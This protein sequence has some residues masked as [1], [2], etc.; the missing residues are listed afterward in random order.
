[1]TNLGGH[2]AIGADARAAAGL[3]F[4]D[5][6]GQAH[7]DEA[8]VAHLIDKKV[9]GLE[10]AVENVLHVAV[11][12]H[13]DDL[14]DDEAHLLGGETLLSEDKLGE[15]TSRYQIHHQDE[16]LR[17][18][19]R[20]REIDKEWVVEAGHQILL[21]MNLLAPR[22]SKAPTHHLLMHNLHRVMLA[23]VTLHHLEHLAEA[24][25][26]EDTYQPEVG[27]AGYKA[28]LG[29]EL[30]DVCKVVGGEE[31]GVALLL[32]GADGLRLCFVVQAA[33]FVLHMIDGLMIGVESVQRRLHLLAVGIIITR[34]SHHAILIDEVGVDTVAHLEECL[35]L[36]LRAVILYVHPKFKHCER[37]G[38]GVARV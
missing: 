35:D 4:S 23:A 37:H 11:A 14:H 10:I 26:S 18:L 7:V 1:M 31:G 27:Q 15:V 21:E 30:E 8:H 12:D 13:T 6:C 28:F 5:A 36:R 34:E 24:S 2:V 9:L 17:V 25:L 33:A 19:E 38:V 32:D 29:L 16:E 22:G 3:L 20:V